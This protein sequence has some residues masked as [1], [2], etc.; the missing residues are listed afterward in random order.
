MCEIYCFSIQNSIFNKSAVL[1]Y[2]R[3]VAASMISEEDWIEWS[4]SCA[5]LSVIV[6]MCS[7]YQSL[8]SPTVHVIKMGQCCNLKSPLKK[9]APSSSPPKSRPDERDERAKQIDVI[10]AQV[11]WRGHG[12]VYKPFITHWAY[13]LSAHL[14]S[15]L[16]SMSW[17][18]MATNWPFLLCAQSLVG[19]LVGSVS[20]VRA[21][22]FSLSFPLSSTCWLSNL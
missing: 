4:C 10:N 6:E 19:G 21:H 1:H 8:T 2:R 16:A 13:L 11:V 15:S 12:H 20:N 5:V 3:L 17:I 14:N 22:V 7:L 18:L 9:I